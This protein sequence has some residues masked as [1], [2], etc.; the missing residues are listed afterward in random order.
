MSEKD[1]SLSPGA[2]RLEL[3]D[4]EKEVLRR[5]ID[6]PESQ[7]S[8]LA[9]LYTCTTSYELLL[10]VISS[11]AAIIGGAL[12]PVSF[13]LLGGL[14]QAFKEFF[15]GTSSGSHLSS[16]VAKFALY[17]VCIAIGQFVSVYIS[18]AGFMI[19]GEKITQRL[20]EKYLAAI[21]RQNI[22]FFDVLG[23]GEITTRITS[24]MNL[25]Q[26]SLTGKLSL[27][28]YSCSNFG[29]A[30]IISFV[31]SWRM[32]LILI[33]A[34]VA[35]TGSMSFFS[36]FMVKYTHKSLAA[37][38]EGS[39]AA[40]EAISS[41][42][43]VTAF[44][45]QDK[46]ADRYQRFL[47]QA[48]KYGLRSRIALAAMMAVMNGV[49]FWT[50]GLTFWQGS[51]YL[52]V[53]DVELG[54]L[55]T[56]LLATLTGAFTFGN[57][58]PNFQAFSTGIAAT[59]K[60]LAT[61]SRESPLDPSSTTGR[62]LEAVSGTIELKSIRY[63]YPSRPDVLTLD[64]VNL[65]FPAGKTTAIVGASGCG[66]S[67][68]AG[69]IERFYEPLSGE[70]LLDG[71]DIA[72][73]NLQ[74]YR[75]QIAIVTQQPT[76]FAT[77]VFQNIRF[78]LVGTEHENSPPDVI[79]SLVFD[80]AK[81]ANCFDFIANLPKGFHTSAERLVQAALDV[82]AKGR[83]TI[84]ISHRLSTIT[85][86]ENIVVMSH[87]GV[88]E[89]GTHSDLLEK[90]S[91]Y[92][93]LVEKQRM[94]TERDV[95]PS[96]ERS[97]FD[98]DAELPGSKDEGNESH[99]HTYQIEQDPV[100][101][102]QDGDSDGKAD[103]RFSLWELIK[104]VANFNKQETFT[105]LWGL[106]FS[107]I[108]G[109]GNPTQAV[110]Y[111]KAIAALSL[112]PNMYGQ[113]RDDVNFWSLMYLMLGG[114]AFLG[115]GASGLCFAYCSERLIH[116]A[117][118]SSFRAILHQD[119][120]MF[121]KPGFSA[122]SITAT[123]STDATNLA[124]ISGVTLGSIFIVSTTLVAGV[125]VSI[126]IGWKLGLVCTATI[127]I[128]LTCGLVRLKLLG[129]IAQQSKAAYA[130]SAAYACE[131][132]SAIKTVASLNLET[133]VQKEYHTI[134]ET[135]RK[136]SVISTLKSS[137]FYAASQ[138]ANFLCIALAFWYGGSLIIHE[139]YSMVQFFI[140]Y[141]AVIAGAFSAGA[142]FSFAP[143]M[144]KSRQAAQDIKTLLSRPVT[145]DTRQ[146]TGE[147]LPNM[148]GSLE[149]RNIYF[150]YP[151][152]P[153]SVVLNG[154]SLSVQT[155]QYIGLVGAS[156]CGK[157]TI[158]S[159]LERFFDPEAGTILV[160]G[161]DISKLNIK[162]YRSHLA[163]VSQE[164]TLYQG[165]IRENIIIGTD[166]DNLCEERVI[167]ACKDANIYDF[168][169][170]LPDG[171]STV[172]GARG[173]MLS[174][175]QQ[176][177]IAIARA[178]LRDPRILLLDEATSA[179]DS[180]SEKVVQDALNAAAQGRTTVAVAHRISTVQK[181]DCIYVLHEGN[182]VEQGTHLELMELGG[183]YFELVKLQSLESI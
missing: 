35:E 104:F 69:L 61:V 121:D 30:L 116:R 26:D 12:Q 73:L 6:T 103:G 91:V 130:A 174:G 150:R 105:M 149:I 75:Q 151:S 68:L 133:H 111:G 7:M 76:L 100:S 156:G 17:Y 141:A 136:K 142:I 135:Q 56:I 62:R 39:T 93:E 21:L 59:G 40:E 94:S 89:Q 65:R 44:G 60:I 153:E 50:Y 90:R 120:S 24:D 117:R 11:I 13:L 72:S 27:T 1:G 38:A 14:A 126:A 163:L 47:T 119:I 92:Y 170:S 98:M 114:T 3:Q 127:P 131:A 144:S 123:L 172:I 140:A 112:P 139:G 2:L 46:L 71:H 54:A 183:R 137:M 52:V 29:A 159:L 181:A 161:K 157:S 83:T 122:G 23:A 86:A 63:V 152:R 171:F 115:W 42:R 41:I 9:L 129:E 128:V 45:I 164:P 87:G 176:Q 80:A 53:G 138:S 37:Y 79:E 110:F 70:I 107:V 168:I 169:L 102:G 32:A 180:E 154:L 101:E 134:L 81:T 96:E 155:G 97:T 33:S 147:Q 66:K 78:G 64:D 146:K 31:E 58:A 88:V 84:T 109:A 57:I 177:R 5:Q 19:G 22:A 34:Y 8:R 179:L 4:D 167:Q 99:K 143:D 125:A 55:I 36:S 148:D 160:D 158:I 82:A 51:R 15:I 43:H 95:G 25:I 28:L 49:I 20:R 165:T 10:L 182:V 175:G 124:G 173:G 166:D 145:I 162:S 113:L 77:T 18:T 85:A 67:T 132:S 74:W 178:L 48:E 118:D 108:T 106:I 16:L